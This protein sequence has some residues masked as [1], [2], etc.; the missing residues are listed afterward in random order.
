VQPTYYGILKSTAAPSSLLTSITSYW[1]LNESSGSAID[2]TGLHNLTNSNITYS[3]TG[4]LNT[5]YSFNGTSSYTGN[6]VGS[7]SYTFA[8]AMSASFWMKTSGT[9][10]F[11]FIVSNW[12]ATNGT[13]WL[14]YKDTDDNVYFEVHNP[15]TGAATST[16]AITGS[17][18]ADGNWHHIVGTFD[19]TYARIYLDS[20][21]EMT[22]SAWPYS[23]AANSNTFSIGSDE[24]TQYY[25]SGYLDEVGL[26]SRAITQTEVNKLYNSGAG[27][28]YPF[29]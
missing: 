1:T 2:S 12:N 13:G 25:Y 6:L 19:G 18:Q 15:G 27:K 10:T 28:T 14:V 17:S 29:S 8:A 3:Q 4:K 22:S 16:V 24:T 11:M 7:A 20:T 5:C 26:W 9:G 21:L 23:I